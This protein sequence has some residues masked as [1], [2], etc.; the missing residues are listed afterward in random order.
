MKTL[1]LIRL[2]AWRNSLEQ[3]SW[4]SFMLTLVL[5]QAIGPL[6]GLLVWTAVDPGSA[7]VRT[8]FVVLLAVQLLT[9]SYE[10]H[11]L[12]GSIFDGSITRQLLLPQPVLIDFA[13]MNL[14]LRFWH[15]VFGLPIVVLVGAAAGLTL[16][17]GDLLLAVP[18]LV[19]AGVLR[20]VFTLAL[21]M[22]AFWT[23]LSVPSL[24]C[25]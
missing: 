4:R 10:D 17:P 2:A 20:F 19:V 12:C 8:Y 23:E 15:T 21:A 3:W 16:D 22:T 14:S 1:R 18:A 5:N 11:T 13:G 9:V 24:W 25:R 6:I 7:Q